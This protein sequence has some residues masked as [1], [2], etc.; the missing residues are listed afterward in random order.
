MKFIIFMD[1][2]GEDASGKKGEF[3]KILNSK[4]VGSTHNK[5]QGQSTYIR[6]F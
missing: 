4:M 1:A 6:H 3:W 2:G 5:A